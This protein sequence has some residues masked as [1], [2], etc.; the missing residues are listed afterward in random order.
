MFFVHQ[1]DSQHLGNESTGD[2]GFKGTEREKTVAGCCAVAVPVSVRFQRARV[3][4]LSTGWGALWEKGERLERRGF[5]SGLERGMRGGAVGVF[6]P[7]TL[8]R[9]H[10]PDDCSYS[11]SS[12]SAGCIAARLCLDREKMK[13]RK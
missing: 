8:S 2:V 10:A 13:Y 11:S 4:W 5:L 3:S 12:P 9:S 1:S 6:N 7:R